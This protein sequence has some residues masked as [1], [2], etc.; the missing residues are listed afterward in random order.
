MARKTT[1]WLGDGE[2]RRL[3]VE[4]V[5]ETS[6][7]AGVS[8][9]QF[10]T[11][12]GLGGASAILAACGAASGSPAA[13]LTAEPSG[14][15][16]ATEGAGPAATA[17]SAV[18]G[19]TG[20]AAPD[21]QQVFRIAFA[22]DPASHDFNKDLYCGGE[23]SLFAGLT[24]LSADYEPQPYAA[25]SWSVSPDG[26]VYTFKLNPKGKWTNG[27][28]VTAKDFV[29]SFL[30]QL[31]PETAASYAAI[32]YDIKGAQE[33][34]T[35]K[36]GSADGVGIRA[37][38]DTTLEITLKGPREYFPLLVGYASALPAH[39]ATVEKFGDK[40]T[41]AEHIVSN[42]PFKLIR[43]DHNKELEFERYE[44]FALAEKPKLKRVLASII[45]NNAGL[46][47]YESDQ[48][49]YR[50]DQGIPATEIERLQHDP[51]LSKQLVSVR[52][53]ATAFL[54]PEVNKPPFDQLGVRQA[55]QHAIDRETILKVIYGLGEPAYSL[56]SQDQPYAIDPKAHPEFASAYTFDPELAKSKLK[57]T[58]YEGGK[59][60]PEV[61]LT[62]RPVGPTGKL[63]AEVIQQQLAQ[64]LGLTVKVE[65]PEDSKVFMA[66][67]Y[68]GKQQFVFYIWYTDYPD[69][70]NHYNAIW[71]GQSA[72]RR[73]AWKSD[74][75]DKLLDAAAGE[76]DKAK[77]ADLYIQAE[78]LMVQDAAYIPLYYASAVNVFKP[79]VQGLL[80][81][82]SG[83]P[84]TDGSVYR[85]MKRY[86]Y[87]AEH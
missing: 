47:P 71:Y 43:W 76:Q 25:E 57:G 64:N 59:N 24:T 3:F 74:A 66:D 17:Q 67:L 40:W 46:L 30:R 1:E 12:L 79:Y 2:Q 11:A 18:V 7:R 21:D 39:Q 53:P 38:D 19:T 82:K 60:W 54:S 78:R 61:T 63:A 14:A 29:Y 10:L 33:W 55:L 4:R 84:V 44:D 49:D 58:P 34:N 56:V 85:N 72:R 42:G 8:R 87:I 32:L 9:R 86:L 69:P 36:G 51:E 31:N 48:I 83:L 23:S 75:F 62:L 16:G 6:A 5:A 37:V 70:S 28:P 68:A 13:E 45:P 65:S 80:S 73:F 15:A 35:G 26:T 52:R 77:R 41:E 50:N 20:K 81:G 27:E 22:T